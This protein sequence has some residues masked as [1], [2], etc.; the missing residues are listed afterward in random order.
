MRSFSE[1]TESIGLT[2]RIKIDQRKHE[3]R[4]S[5]SKNRDL[6]ILEKLRE[7]TELIVGDSVVA[8]NPEVEQ[9]L[10]Q[11]L[12]VEWTL[13]DNQYIRED[14]PSSLVIARLLSLI[15]RKIPV[16]RSSSGINF[17][18]GNDV[19]KWL[20]REAHLAL[21]R[22]TPETATEPPSERQGQALWNALH[23]A[24]HDGHTEPRFLQ[25]S[26]M[27]EIIADAIDSEI[28]ENAGAGI[29]CYYTTPP[30]QW[31]RSQAILAAKQAP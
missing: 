27:L 31:L 20:F 13:I 5:M 16:L 7:L 2:R 25:F 11:D 6:L 17:T 29:G 12:A 4:Q 22:Q 28:T 14:P 21:Y 15:A 24:W 1:L 3:I 30:A 19:K 26:R 9:S 10:W 8:V 18:T 23:D